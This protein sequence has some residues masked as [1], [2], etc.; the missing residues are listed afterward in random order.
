MTHMPITQTN[1]PIQPDGSDI[2]FCSYCFGDKYLEQQIRLHNSILAVYPNANTHFLN[3]AEETGKPRFQQSLYGFKVALVRDCLARGFK[4]IIF[5]DTATTLANK[6]DH[7]FT[8]T[9]E[10]G[11]LAAIDRQT[12]NSVTSNACLEYCGLSREDVSNWNLLGGSIYVF[13]FDEEK[14]QEIFSVWEN[15]ERDGI[16]GT[17]DD[18]S[19]DRLQSHRMDETCM[20]LAMKLN[21]VVPLGHDV[22]KYGYIHPGDGSLHSSLPESELI[23]IKRHFK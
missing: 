8:L 18:L 23:I 4:K 5:L 10:F 17:Q 7:W 9:P 3:E 12:L 11:V 21:G 13:D 14:C 20:A 6:V 22:M 15:M 16:F 2:I 1:A 19:N